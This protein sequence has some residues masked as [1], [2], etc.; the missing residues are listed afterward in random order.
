MTAKTAKRVL[1]TGGGGFLGSAIVRQLVLRGDRVTSLARNL[2]GRLEALDVRQI[3]ADISDL[4][5][6]IRACRGMDM[7]FHT[8]AK[9][10]VWGDYEAYYRS[11]VM[12]TENIVTACK[13]HH[14]PVL[15]HTSSPSVVFDGTDMEG[16]DESRPYPKSFP[17]HY[18]KTKAMAE[19]LVRSA[20]EK[21]DIHALILRP[22]LIW[23]PGDPH[24]VPRVLERA[25][26]LVKVGSRD[27]LVDTIYIEDAAA[28]HILAG[29]KLTADPALS[30][31]IYFISQ[32]E[33]IPMWEMINGIL[34]AGGL[35]PINRTMPAGLVWLIAAALEGIYKLVGIKNEPPMTRF[36]AKE[37]STAH[38]F[39]IS[40]A[41]RDLGYRPRF[42]VRQGLENLSR[43]LQDQSSQNIT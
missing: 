2:Y 42:T 10:G 1:V 8:A 27:N 38:W 21:G 6:V 18:V 9:A 40:A 15:I 23:G 31:R 20:A 22:H 14:I 35:R 33:P 16:V 43:W 13:H 37:L 28:A 36:V 17:T 7:V 32:D 26:K 3:Q 4:N 12:G 11:N 39:D 29:D 25:K 30:G 34:E 41:K 5:A 24:L 19:Q